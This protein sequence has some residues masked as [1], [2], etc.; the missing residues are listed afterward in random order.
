MVGV[1]VRCRGQGHSTP[2]TEASFPFPQL[3]S[4]RGAALR[5]LQC[6][7]SLLI[8]HSMQRAPTVAGFVAV[9]CSSLPTPLSPSHG[10]TQPPTKGARN[11][12]WSPALFH[13]H[14]TLFLLSGLA[15]T[16]SSDALLTPAPAFPSHVPPASPS[17]VPGPGALLQLRARHAAGQ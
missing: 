12:E 13:A 4:E 11:C 1:L 2:T 16:R 5:F 3:P 15:Y 17:S 10:A 14:D 9:G 6:T 8:L 7:A